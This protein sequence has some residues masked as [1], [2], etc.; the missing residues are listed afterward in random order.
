MNPKL[1]L[2]RLT[3]LLGT[4]LAI[5]APCTAQKS[6]SSKPRDGGKSATAARS[7]AASRFRPVDLPTS[8]AP[9]AELKTS[10]APQNAVFSLRFRVGPLDPIYALAFSPDGKTLAVGMLRTVLLWDMT[11]GR[12]AGVLRDLSGV[13]YSLAWSPDG[14][15]LAAAGGDPSVSGEIRLYHVQS[16]YRPLK[17]LA[18]H[19]DVVYSVA[20]SPDGKILVSAGHDRTVRTWETATGKNLQTIRSHS[21]VVLRAAFLDEGRTIL[22]AGMD[23]SIRITDAATGKEQRSIEGHNQPI[24]ALAA[25]PDGQIILTSGPE[26]R[27]FWRSLPNG[28][29]VRY[30]DGHGG[31]VNDIV[32]SKDGKLFASSS[33]DR[34]VRLWDAVNGGQIRS[35]GNS[36]DGY[37]CAAISPDSSVIAGGSGDGTVRIWDADS[38]ALRCYLTARAWQATGQVEWALVSP[39]GYFTCSPGWEKIAELVFPGS[40][41]GIDAAEI[42][43]AL[44]SADNSVKALRGEAVPPVQLP[45]VKQ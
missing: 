23:R 15:L 39:S 42:L 33:A 34:T 43:K 17:P 22:S 27:I 28:N 8:I 32:Y 30:G 36:E 9:P 1:S 25:R 26:V 37:F 35:F 14:S 7:S 6:E 4:S 2:K 29:I 40:K 38:G 31:Q 12:P 24:L 19:T 44:R 41:P 21:D 18:D 5:T 20:F 3:F 45:P 10:A 13:V 16:G 11:A